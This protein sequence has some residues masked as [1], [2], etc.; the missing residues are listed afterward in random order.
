MPSAHSAVPSPAG[1]T[2]SPDV[3]TSTSWPST[4]IWTVGT[5]ASSADPDSLDDS[6]VPGSSP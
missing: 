3:S 5:I 6:V 2:G 1:S 4:S